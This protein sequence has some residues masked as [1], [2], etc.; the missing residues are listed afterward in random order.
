MHKSTTQD[1]GHKLH[2]TQVNFTITFPV[3]TPYD[4][5]APAQQKQKPGGLVNASATYL[6]QLYKHI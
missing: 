2:L 1:I 5:R 6:Q 3:Q 4:A